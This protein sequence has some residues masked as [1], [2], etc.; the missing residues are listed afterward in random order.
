M[1]RKTTDIVLIS[2]ILLLSGQGVFASDANLQP[3]RTD[4]LGIHGRFEG[5]EKKSERLQQKKRAAAVQESGFRDVAMRFS[6][7]DMPPPNLKQKHSNDDGANSWLA[8]LVAGL[9]VALVSI[10]RRMGRIR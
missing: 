8:M 10:I 1:R 2:G 3:G 6:D 4:R 9:G 5:Y 7:E